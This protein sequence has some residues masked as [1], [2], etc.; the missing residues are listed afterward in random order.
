LSSGATSFYSA[1]PYQISNENFLKHKFDIQSPITLDAPGPY[2]A[3][4]VPT[5]SH[6][7]GK[8]SRAT[9]VVPFARPWPRRHIINLDAACAEGAE[10]DRLQAEQRAKGEFHVEQSALAAYIAQNGEVECWDVKAWIDGTT[11][12]E[13]RAP[14]TPQTAV[15]QCKEYYLMKSFNK[16]SLHLECNAEE[17]RPDN[18]M[19]AGAAQARRNAR[20]LEVRRMQ[21]VQM[22]Q[23]RVAR[24]LMAED[25]R[26]AEARLAEEARLAGTRYMGVVGQGHVYESCQ[27]DASQLADVTP[28]MHAANGPIAPR[29]KDISRGVSSKVP[30][31]LS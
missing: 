5:S 28:T 21:L 31:I 1:L 24:A 4:L 11:K 9:A 13:K 19:A 3:Y 2:T 30:L 12:A 7:Y 26:I 18:M 29:S 10:L 16:H 22:E 23:A 27:S 6:L 17:P 8:V 14:V 25:V 20:P 15:R